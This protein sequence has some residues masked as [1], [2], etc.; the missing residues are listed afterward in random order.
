MKMLSIW[1]MLFICASLCS[2]QAQT[3]G[4]ALKIDPPFWWT[5][6]P[7]ASLQLMIH[8]E[9]I[10]AYRASINKPGVTLV[11]QIVGDSPNYLF[12]Y[13]DISPEVKPGD[14]P[15]SL[16]NGKQL[17]NVTYALKARVFSKDKN[18]G[19]SSADLIY[20]LMP[21]R[22]ANG[23][24]NNDNVAGM[25]E[26]V[27]RANPNARHGGDI[28]GIK[29]HL[30]YLVDL[31]LTAVWL[32]PVFENDMK[33]V[34][35]AY[36]GYAATDL[37][38][39]D[40]RFGT[41]EEFL[42]LVQACHDKG[43]KVI[44]DMIHN[45][46][47]DQHWWLKDLPMKDWLHDIDKYGTTS[48][49]GVVQSDPYQSAYDLA[50]LEKGWFVK[51]M[52]DLNQK[53]PQLADYLIQ[54]TLW[55]IEYSGVDGI[56]MDT[57]MY[58]Y[59]DY[60][61]RWAK[62]VLAAYPS[63]NIVGEAWVET[64]AHESYWQQNL[65]GQGDGYESYLPSVTDFQ[66]YFA[67]QKA[68]NEEFGWETGLMRLYFALSQDRLYA[69]PMKNVIFMENH[70][71]E[72]FFTTM[73]ENKAHFKMALAFLLTTRG[74]P[75]VYYGL[76][77]MFRMSEAKGDGAKRV[78]M[79]GGWAGD[80]RDVFTEKDRTPTEREGFDYFRKIAN[81]RKNSSVIHEGKLKHFVP[82]DNVYVY[83]RYTDEETVMV[84]LN[85]NKQ[86]KTISRKQYIEMLRNY[87][88]GKNVLTG[89]TVD[90]H[91]DFEVQGKTATILALSGRLD[92]KLLD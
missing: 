92:C 58:P 5:N 46:I 45:H 72:R 73:K 59:K 55:W 38:K 37:F 14:L 8:G 66:I 7:T 79:P 3:K 50:K 6:M 44:M 16:V 21:D 60:M 54:N 57:Y 81:W 86:S 68:F 31:G 24:P 9:N 15:I 41:N 28:K 76:E 4:S 78:D 67:L 34:Y 36:H 49:R 91:K 22:F 74:I 77:M 43:L 61:A 51:E 17:I 65:P 52:P 87:T 20:L 25:F 26:Q 75:Q 62:E 32:T 40:R 18:K 64:V 53:N 2:L 70:D 84:I 23:N 39:V 90:V 35:G 56:R 85:N 11:R 89:N 1:L 69:D 47:G 42:D 80:A 13:I 33:P 48:Y 71:T 27:D 82:V 29:D 88:K 30:D 83:F 19:F 63:F 12:I 10:S